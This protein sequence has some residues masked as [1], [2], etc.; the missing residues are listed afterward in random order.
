M[1]N[2]MIALVTGANRGIGTALPKSLHG[3]AGS[4]DLLESE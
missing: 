3:Y 2:E 4:R 1:K